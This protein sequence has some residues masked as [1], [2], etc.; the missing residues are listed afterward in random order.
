M[1]YLDQQL[2]MKVVI[3]QLPSS[4]GFLV[5]GP[6]IFGVAHFD[7]LSITRAEIASEA[8]WKW[9]LEKR[10]SMRRVRHPDSRR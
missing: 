1:A 9:D 4:H 10:K 5:L 7:N 2:I 8:E 3:P 6:E